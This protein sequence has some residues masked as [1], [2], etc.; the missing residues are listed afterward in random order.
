[1]AAV[2]LEEAGGVGTHELMDYCRPGLCVV[3]ESSDGWLMRG[4]RG[5]VEFV[6][7]VVG[8]SVHASV[9]E[10]GGGMAGRG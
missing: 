9:P 8:R 2:V 1:V 4:H 6:A 5:R 3:G 7:R 10:P